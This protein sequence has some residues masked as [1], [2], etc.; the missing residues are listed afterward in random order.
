ME[1][2]N[3]LI[4]TFMGSDGKYISHKDQ[5]GGEV[6]GSHEPNP[7]HWDWNLLMEVVD[8]VDSMLTDD[9]FVVIEYNR[10]WINVLE[11]GF[12]IDVINNSR[13]QAVYL[14]VVQY[15]EWYNTKN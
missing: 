14:A 7:Y 4:D 3:R 2:T 8:Y 1:E 5:W 12:D 15:I 10:C 11:G 13:K 6:W 9:T